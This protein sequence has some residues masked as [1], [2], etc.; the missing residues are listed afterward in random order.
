MLAS[1]RE[2]ILDLLDAGDLV[3]DVGGGASPFPRADWVLDL[4]PYEER[5]R[6]GPPP[7]PRSERFT[8]ATWI[9]RDI[10]DRDRWPFEDRQFDFAVCSH[11]LEDVRDPVFV[12]SEL[13]RVSKAGYIEV[14]SRLEEQSYGVH[15]PWIGW[16]HHRWLID[17]GDGEIVFVH[18]PHLL[19]A[20]ATDH[21]PAGFRESLTLEAR[22]QCLWWRERFGYREHIFL[23]AP[24]LDAWLEEFVRQHRRGI[25]ERRLGAR[26][27]RKRRAS[28][29][30]SQ[31][32]TPSTTDEATARDGIDRR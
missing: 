10:C 21:F 22:V 12:C 16:S 31:S 7:D 19:H 3:L 1:S 8:A 13:I 27:R 17:V 32:G 2:R 29:V 5:G 4:M 20:R 15:G 18:K 23:D 9:R 24:S 6:Y 25:P 30:G 11:T 14:P 28:N 26:L